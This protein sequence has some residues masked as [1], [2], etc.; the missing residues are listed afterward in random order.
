MA[1]QIL[2]VDDDKE[3]RDELSDFLQD[4]KVLQASNGEEAIKL[5]KKPN[6]IDLVILDVVMSGAN[7]IEVL[8]DMKRVAPYL[9]VVMLTGKSSKDIAVEALRGNAD[10]YLEKPIDLEKLDESIKKILRQREKELPLADGKNSKIEQAKHYVAHNYDKMVNLND[11]ASELCL[12]PKYFSRMFKE[13]A[14]CGFNEYKL[15]IKMEKAEEWL[16]VNQYSIYEIS[17]RLGYKNIESFVRLFKKTIGLT[18]AVY[19]NKYCKNK[20]VKNI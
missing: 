11:V 6:L 10:D 16:R 8:K 19:R 3:F 15:K 9:S 5:I 4:Y 13:N 12:S 2:I 18:P 20:R 1:Y 17:Q 7:G 14:G